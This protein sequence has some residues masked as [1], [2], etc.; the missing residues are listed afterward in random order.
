MPL[1]EG[2]RQSLAQRLGDVDPLISDNGRRAPDRRRVSVRWLSGS[3]LTGFA[4]VLLMGGALYAALDGRHQL[5][6]PPSTID[7]LTQRNGNREVV[8]GDRPLSIVALEPSREKVLQVPTMTRVGESN[9]IRKKPFAYAEA[10]LA[11]VP[12][13]KVKYA[14]FNPL[15]VFSSSRSDNRKVASS[16][17]IYSANIENEVT[18]K[19]VDFPLD[20]A[21]YEEAQRISD[22]QAETAVSNARASLEDGQ[23]QT[24]ALAYLDTTRFALKEEEVAPISTLGITMVAENVTRI[25]KDE[26]D[27]TTQRPFAE[28]VLVIARQQ[29]V[30]AALSAMGAEENSTTSLAEALSKE[31]GSQEL[32]PGMRLRVAWERTAQESG[33]RLRRVSAYRRGS[34]LASAVL[35][36]DS[37]IIIAKAPAPIEATADT[38]DSPQIATVARSNLPNVYDG[39][40]RAALSQGLTAEHAKRIVRTVAFDVDFRRQIGPKDSLEVFYSLPEGEEQASADSEI[41]YIGL[42]LQ[43]QKRRYY[44]FR[45]GRDGEIDY[46]DEDGKSAKK[47]L[48]RKTVP[49]GRFRSKF[50]MRLHPISRRQKMHWGVDF[51]APRGTPIIA[52]GNGVVEKAGWAG[53][54]GRQ[55]I[56]RHANGY[57]TSYNHMHRFAKGIRPG[58]RVRLGEI[59]GQVG[60]TGYSTG[61]HLHYE[62][63][64]NG[65]KV[66]PMGIRLPK[67]KVL[68]G[69]ELSAF[70]RE[71]RRIDALLERSRDT[72]ATTLASL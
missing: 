16:D 36:D 30:L 22:M 15:S 11:I 21:Q 63:I 61:P 3:I 34:H 7:R 42:T 67:G 43:G 23:V 54:Y 32:T 29:T 40:H 26:Y 27:G 57:K 24:M 33:A 47:F 52:A 35:D 25:E 38:G 49:N 4:S 44:R 6:E 31:I 66:N 17:F 28:E 8:K 45:S 41:L 13:R 58:A 56:L 18:I 5:A 14:A 1:N 2:T 12:L 48:L 55:V 46:F 64:V 72:D 39:I 50:G 19:T 10:P 37:R 65:R 59:I 62:V 53:G 69:R 71:R 9:V 68:K 20:S 51:S 60:S 70:K